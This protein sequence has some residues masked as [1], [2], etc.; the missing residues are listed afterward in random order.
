MIDENQRNREQI[1]QYKLLL[2][3]QR[4]QYTQLL[5]ETEKRVV[6]ANMSITQLY[7]QELKDEDKR[8]AAEYLSAQVY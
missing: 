3:K 1:V 8:K 7:S 2:Q 4:D 6:Q 5:A